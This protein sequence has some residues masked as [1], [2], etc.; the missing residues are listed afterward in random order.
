[1]IQ[2][3]ILNPAVNKLLIAG[4]ITIF[5]ACT[6]K[7]SNIYDENGTLLETRRFEKSGDTTICKQTLY[8]PSKI[9]KAEGTVINGVKQ[10]FGR[11]Y[12]LDGSLRWEGMYD[13]GRRV[14]PEGT[15]PVIWFSKPFARLGDTIGVRIRNIHYQ[16]I[17]LRFGFAEKLDNGNYDYMMVAENIGWM[18]FGVCTYY[19][20]KKDSGV[21]IVYPDGTYK[22]K[23]KTQTID[24]NPLV[25]DSIYVHSNE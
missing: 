3:Y 6:S 16:D 23:D 24:L 14:Y 13:D 4:I 2:L 5:C 7:E 18:K 15:R 12:Y 10:G 8:Y 11:D 25:I 22:S 19:K 1:M 17:G 21:T 20:I 9:V